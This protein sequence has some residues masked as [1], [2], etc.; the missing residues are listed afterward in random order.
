MD[1]CALREGEE[2]DRCRLR[3]A[4]AVGDQGVSHW[5]E[6]VV[7]AHSGGNL[8]SVKDEEAHD[9]SLRRLR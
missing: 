5:L 7:E 1:F 3:L 8:L 2:A 6:E 4:G 9:V